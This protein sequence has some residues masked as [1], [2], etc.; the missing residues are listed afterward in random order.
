MTECLCPAR[1]RYKKHQICCA[2]ETTALVRSCVAYRGWQLCE[3]VPHPNSRGNVW[4]GLT[5]EDMARDGETWPW[6]VV[7][8]TMTG[9]WDIWRYTVTAKTRQQQ[10]DCSHSDTSIACPTDLPLPLMRRWYDIFRK[11]CWVMF[12][13]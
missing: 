5:E 1:I 2:R 6:N 12:G 13:T 3:E 10:Q 4:K 9:D 11:I 8:E 7:I